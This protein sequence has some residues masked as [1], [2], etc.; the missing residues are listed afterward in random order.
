[1]TDYTSQTWGHRREAETQLFCIVF[2]LQFLYNVVK[3][4]WST[5]PTQRRSDSNSVVHPTGHE[6]FCCGPSFIAD[7]LCNNAI[8]FTIL[9]A[10]P[11]ITLIR[12]ASSC[13]DADAVVKCYRRFRF[14]I[15][16]LLAS[17]FKDT[18]A[19]R[20]LQA[21]TGMLISGSTA[22]QLFLRTTYPDSDLDLY[23]HRDHRLLVGQ[24]LLDAGYTFMH[25]RNQAPDFLEAAS[26]DFIDSVTGDYS[27]MYGVATVFTFQNA[28][29]KTVQVIL[30]VSSPLAV[31][32]LYHSTC[33]LNIVT[34]NMAFCLYP[35]ATLGD[36]CS[37]VLRS[38]EVLDPSVMRKY[39]KRG[40]Q[41][42]ISTRQEDVAFL[43]GQLRWLGDS[44]CWTI[45]LNASM[46]N[47]VTEADSLTNS[48]WR[49]ID[50]PR[51]RI[52]FDTLTGPGFR[53][54][55]V[56]GDPT[57][58]AIFTAFLLFSNALLEN[59]ISYD[60][61]LEFRRFC[62]F[63]FLTQSFADLSLCSKSLC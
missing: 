62:N 6:K 56:V 47:V 45:P 16:P 49:L 29:F 48:S 34:Y 44:H 26:E 63:W 41:F 32:L 3:R 60:F 2:L 21:K 43:P 38:D 10:C 11:P 25:N 55:Y 13:R 24:Y 36:R 20:N 42:A 22:L 8:N 30:A 5:G 33:V 27:R 31:I 17:F 50:A 4:W 58:R 19:F 18:G 53:D 12:L 46:I 52:E 7:L 54:V 1:M 40:F 61:D 39:V 37:L 28:E 35:R 14:D 23:V 9:D 15:D 57:I 51:V 59:G